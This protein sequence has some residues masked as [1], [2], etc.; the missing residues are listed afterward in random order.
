MNLF[1]YLHSHW[2]REW[3]LPLESYRLNLIGMV[4]NLINNI[5]NHELNF[6]LL[7]GQTIILEDI[8]AIEPTLFQR[9]TD[10]IKAKKIAI[11][12]W[13][14]LGDQSLVCGES[15]IRNLALGLKLCAQL[16]SQSN[17][18]YC[19]DTFGHCAD[20]PR[21]LNLFGIQTA[22]VWRGVDFTNNK[23]YFIWRSLDKSQ[24]LTYIFEHGYYNGINELFN[25]Q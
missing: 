11:G 22:I 23:P 10:L 5:E 9:L 17:I 7:D 12:P 25:R 19:P 14:I 3:Y 2:D 21:I 4:K 13:Y 20:L 8:Q 1:Y 16:G 15:I 6:F 18:G 24:V